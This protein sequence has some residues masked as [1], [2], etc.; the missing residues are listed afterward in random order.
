MIFSF[1]VYQILLSLLA[2]FYI[3]NIFLKFVRRESRQTFVKFFFSE[4]I[5]VSMLIL[6]IFPNLPTNVSRGLGFGEN[7]N[8]LI[9]IGFVIVFIILFKLLSVVEKLEMSITEL[10][11]KEALKDV[12][13]RK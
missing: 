8:T 2:I 1:S 9:F 7:L 6:S 12:E 3:V 13:K 11:R 5:W 4:L 10:V